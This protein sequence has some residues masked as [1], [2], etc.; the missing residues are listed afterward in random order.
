MIKIEWK[1]VWNNKILIIVVMAII[2]IPVI[3][4][5]CF[6]IDG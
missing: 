4:Q 1:S 5:G 3:F 2:I 6:H